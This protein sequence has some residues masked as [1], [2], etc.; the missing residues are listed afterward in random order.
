MTPEEKKFHNERQR[1]EQFLN[2]VVV[3]FRAAV[4]AKQ[5]DAARNA[6]TDLAQ[7]IDE[8]LELVG[9]DPVWGSDDCPDCGQFV[10][11]AI[12]I[13]TEGEGEDDITES[14]QVWLD[15]YGEL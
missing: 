1:C 7:V 2:A 5:A 12:D 6:A 14:Q 15:S 3:R 9:E 13:L 10:P 8:L 11:D 4:S